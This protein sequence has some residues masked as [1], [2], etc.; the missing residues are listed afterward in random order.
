[1]RQD[2]LTHLAM[3]EYHPP[4]Q[5][6]LPKITVTAYRGR[7]IGLDWFCLKSEALLGLPADEFL[8]KKHTQLS[9]HDSSERVLLTT[10]AQLDEYFHGIRCRFELP[11]EFNPFGHSATVFQIKTWQALWDIPYGQTISYAMLAERIGKPS[12]YR[13][14]ANANGK[15]PISL[16]VPCHRVIASH[17]GLGGYTGGVEIKETLLHHERRCGFG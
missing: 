1:M 15:N 3:T 14:V 12:A 8:L 16:V 13:A 11:L 6:N 17:G 7:L 5:F 2:F 9:V 4:S 10:L